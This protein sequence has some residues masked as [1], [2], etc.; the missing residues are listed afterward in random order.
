AGASAIVPVSEIGIWAGATGA[1]ASPRARTKPVFDMGWEDGGREDLGA[2]W[3]RECSRRRGRTCRRG[4]RRGGAR[5]AGDAARVTLCAATAMAAHEQDPR[6]AEPRAA[7]AVRAAVAPLVVAMARA[8]GL[9]VAVGLELLEPPSVPGAA[10]GC[11][12]PATVESALR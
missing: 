6:G 2:R 3:V 11:A 8:R 4:V 10:P 7:G 12:V 9:S 5:L 1:R